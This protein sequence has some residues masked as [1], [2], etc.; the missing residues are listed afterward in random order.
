M[1]RNGKIKLGRRTRRAPLFNHGIAAV[2]Q[3]KVRKAGGMH[4]RR[5]LRGGARN[6]QAEYAN[7]YDEFLLDEALYGSEDA[8]SC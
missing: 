6:V 7:E 3:G 5:A 4:D 1:A 8:L 2:L